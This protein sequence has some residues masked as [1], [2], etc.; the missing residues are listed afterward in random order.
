[1]PP[2]IVYQ[3]EVQS[4]NIGIV[5]LGVDGGLVENINI[6]DIVMTDVL[7]PIF[8]RVGRRFLNPDRDGGPQKPSVMRHIT[9]QNIRAES[10]STIPSIIAGLAESPVE[11]V[12]IAN[13]RVSIPIAVGTD[14]LSIIPALIPKN[15]LTFCIRLPASAFYVCHAKNITLTDIAISQPATEARPAVYVDDTKGLTLRHFLVN[16]KR[17]RDNKAQLAKKGSEAVTID[18]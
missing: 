18:D 16:D 4:V 14:S 5:I 3:P 9:I 8:I 2:S 15:R 13:V 7:G 17:L 1:M 12:R 11:D 10:R 6:S